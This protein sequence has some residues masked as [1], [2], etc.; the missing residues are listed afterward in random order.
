[1]RKEL[2]CVVS[3]LLDCTKARLGSEGSV[4]ILRRS[5]SMQ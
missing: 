5:V 2:V 4:A 1:M 3:I